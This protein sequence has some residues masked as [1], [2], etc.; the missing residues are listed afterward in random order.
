MDRMMMVLEPF[1]CRATLGW[2]ISWAG[3][4]RYITM[5][6]RPHGF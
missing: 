1:P 3:G 5:V 6:N 2:G 4:N